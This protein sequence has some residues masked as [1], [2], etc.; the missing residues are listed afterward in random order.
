[1]D[2]WPEAGG[3]YYWDSEKKQGIIKVYSETLREFL[4][5]TYESISSEIE[6]FFEGTKIDV[7]NW[8]YLRTIFHEFSHAIDQDAVNKRKRNIGTKIIHISDKLMKIED[9]YMDNYEDI[10]IEIKARTIGNIG[11]LTIYNQLSSEFISDSDKAIYGL[12]TAIEIQSNYYLNIEK[13]KIESPSER[14]FE[15]ADNFNL[16][17][18]DI[19]P[20]TLRHIVYDPNNLSLY[21]RLIWGLPISYDEYGHITLLQA[22]LNNGQNIDVVK[23]LKKKK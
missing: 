6:H 15:A 4:D 7:M 5:T 11:A 2:N 16:S 22:A 3:S 14:L 1:M 17:K 13:E 21:K 20:E 18:F 12:L 8:Y 19:N 23:K 9:F 10:P